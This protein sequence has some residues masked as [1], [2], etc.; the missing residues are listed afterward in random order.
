MNLDPT[1]EQHLI[2]EAFHEG[3]NMVVEAGAGTGKTT[4]L[5]SCADSTNDKGIY[6]AY[7]KAIAVEAKRKFPRNVE[8]ATAHS[9]AFRAVG[10][11]Y[12]SRLEQ[13]TW[14][15]QAARILRIFDPIQVGE[16]GGEP[17]YLS[18]KRQAGL[19]YDM[20]QRF[21]FTTDT[22]VDARHMPKVTGIEGDAHWELARY[23]TPFAARAWEDFF[24]PNGRLGWNKMHDLY[25][26][27][28]AL[29][30]PRLP[31]Q[32]ILFDEAQ[33]ANPCTAG[34]VL[35]QQGKQLVAVGDRCQA[36]YGWR[37]AKD[38][39]QTWPAKHRLFLTQSF[40]FGPAVAQEANKWLELLEAE[41]RLSGF[42]KI[43]TTLAELPDNADAVLCR[44]N[45]SVIAEAMTAQEK[46][47]RVAIVGGTKDIQAFAKAVKQL[48]Q[49]MPTDHPDLSIFKNWE[50]VKTYVLQ[51]GGGDLGVIV[52]LIE[53]F[54]VD[55]LQRVAETAVDEKQPHDIVLS[56]AHK[57]K[58]REWDKV[59]IAADFTKPEP[60]PETGEINADPEFMLAY[61]AVTRAQKVLDRGGLSW[62]DDL[63]PGEPIIEGTA[64]EITDLKPAI[65]QSIIKRKARERKEMAK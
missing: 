33:D 24:D 11:N 43:P 3:D 63:L 21:C 14:P 17:V 10:K 38:A 46:D 64:E 20:I 15:E 31:G 16:V 57:A 4:T 35:D 48:Q 62:V 51:E 7:N 32:F 13:K 59:R 60:H 19:V 2:I 18:T 30:K 65:K 58:G 47:K 53:N 44:T 8:C 9:F 42:D 37:G 61:V 1:P 45:A 50:Q 22:Q 40:R 36:I 28:W 26:K 25:L 55:V 6:I 56:T 5:Q 23:L 29:G 34:V 39:M 12:V 41:L 52:R 49:G 27:R 54:G